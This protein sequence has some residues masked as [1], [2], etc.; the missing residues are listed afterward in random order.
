[1][2]LVAIKQKN[3]QTDILSALKEPGRPKSINF[4]LANDEAKEKVKRFVNGQ[5]EDETSGDSSLSHDEDNGGLFVVNEVVINEHKLV[6][7]KLG[8]SIDGFSL[9]MKGYTGSSVNMMSAQRAGKVS[10]GDV[11]SHVQGQIV[12]GEKGAGQDRALSILETVK[13]TPLSLGF[14]KPYLTLIKFQKL[15]GDIGGPEELLFTEK[16]TELGSTRVVLK[17]LQD[18]DGIA[19]SRGVFI[20]DHLIFVNSIPVGAGCRIS[21][22]PPPQ[23][24]EVYAML[25]KEENY[26]IALTFARPSQKIE[27]RNASYSLDINSAESLCVTGHSY[28]QLGFKLKTGRDRGEILVESFHAVKGMIMCVLVWVW[29]FY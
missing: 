27:R 8:K 6:G 12:L 14:V 13:E 9:L 22:S 2:T 17:G 28:H 23:L 11:L 4:L 3:E 24:T 21:K 15:D 29:V 1:M 19:E 16:K 20:G 25:Q 10:T 7:L 18:I 26:P 5:T